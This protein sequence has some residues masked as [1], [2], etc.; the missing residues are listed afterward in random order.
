MFL[1]LFIAY[2][3]SPGTTFSISE[4]DLKEINNSEFDYI[5]T[6]INFNENL[7]IDFES[8]IRFPSRSLNPENSA[9]YT[10]PSDKPV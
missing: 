4:I 9:V 6:A 5:D 2:I 10:L 7:K 8:G 3:L 1:S